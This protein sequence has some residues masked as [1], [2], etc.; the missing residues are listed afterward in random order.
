MSNY[1]GRKGAILVSSSYPG[2]VPAAPV[3]KMTKWSISMTQKQADS[4]GMGDANETSVLGLPGCSGKL[5]GWWDSTDTVLFAAA[6]STTGVMLYIY[7]ATSLPTVYHYGPA[8]LTIDDHS[9]DLSSAVK[10]ELSFAASG[11]WGHVGL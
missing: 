9:G 11:P 6:A 8:W 2:T 5:S 1:H 7:P 3:W 4:T 10:L